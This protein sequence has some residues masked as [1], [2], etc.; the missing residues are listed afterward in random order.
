MTLATKKPR[1]TEKPV[2]SRLRSLQT[3][4]NSLTAFGLHH[5]VLV[6]IS[7]IEYHDAWSLLSWINVLGLLFI[8]GI[9]QKDVS[10]GLM[11]RH[12][13]DAQTERRRDSRSSFATRCLQKRGDR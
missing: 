1:P 5:F 8:H 10:K 12:L 7:Q 11:W 9:S 2:V 13:S 4:G 6:V 3:I